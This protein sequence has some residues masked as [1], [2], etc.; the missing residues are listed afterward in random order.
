MRGRF[1]QVQSHTEIF[2]I[3]RKKKIA[4]GIRTY[5][6]S[7]YISMANLNKLTVEEKEAFKC[8]IFIPI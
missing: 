8:G 5:T 4:R 6:A 1:Y 7:R 3:R 2:E